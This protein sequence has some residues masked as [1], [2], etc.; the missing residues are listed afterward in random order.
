VS[1]H[2]SLNIFYLTTITIIT[3]LLLLV[4][5]L[6]HPADASSSKTVSQT[7]PLPLPRDAITKI[8][9][10]TKDRQQDVMSSSV[11]LG[12]TIVNNLGNRIEGLNLSTAGARF[13]NVITCRPLIAC[14]GTNNDDIIMAAISQQ[15]FGLKGN[16]MIFGASDD[17]LYGRNG[18]DIILAGAGNSLADGGSGDD[19]LTGGIGHSLLAGGPGNDKLFAGPGDTVMNGGGG[20]NHFDCP[21]SIAGLARSIVLDYNP[22]NGDTISGKCTLINNVGPTDGGTG[23]T[24]QITLPDTGESSSGSSSGTEGVMASRGGGAGG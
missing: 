8:I 13:G 20:A 17:Q 21:V 23:S 5:P 7:S 3:S 24:P 11:G 22:S 16:D 10:Q 1:S 6:N 12:G 9:S 2:I 15:V 4:G 18:N 14:V 19:V